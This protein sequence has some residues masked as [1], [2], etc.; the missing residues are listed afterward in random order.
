MR[1]VDSSPALAQVARELSGQ[2]V[3]FIDTEFESTRDGRTLCLLQVSSGE[4]VYLVDPLRVPKL[5]PLI[6]VFANPEVEWVLHAG[7]QDVLLLREQFNLRETPRIFDTQIAWGLLGPEPSVSLAYLQFRLLGL[8]A[9]KAHQADDWKRR[10]LPQS[11]L[12]YAASDIEQLPA[13]R[14][15]LS[16]RLSAKGRLPA[17]FD[18]CHEALAPSQ[19]PPPLLSLESFR[20]AWQLGA[21]SQAALEALIGWYNAQPAG[22][23]IAA[24]APKAMLAIASR[25]PETAD[26]LCRIKGVPM[27]FGKR[28]GAALA[29]LVREAARSAQSEG[30]RPIDPEPY[31]TFREIRLDAY[32]TTLRA[33]V[34]AQLELA[35][36]LA[37]PMRVLRQLRG[38]L[39]QGGSALSALPGWR[40]EVMGDA[41]K[42]HL[43]RHPP[44]L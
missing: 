13:L 22:G 44:P 2:P 11:Q 27:G 7:Q 5:D 17:L 21:P 16:E 32:L 9:G 24:P 12:E 15:A 41:V 38:E 14:A 26:E 31:A 4:R 35:P 37:L 40:G 33:E 10:P 6:P 1:L 36:E 28:H 30:F 43:E 42:A 34:C 8:R 23:R 29:A 19:E 18:A 3:L 39:L 20:N 25:L